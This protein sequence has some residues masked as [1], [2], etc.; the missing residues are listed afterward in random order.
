VEGVIIVLVI[1]N[2]IWEEHQA[3]ELL[4]LRRRKRKNLRRREEHSSERQ[5]TDDL[6]RGREMAGRAVDISITAG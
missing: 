2:R 3:R 6:E 1:W 4:R 5:Y